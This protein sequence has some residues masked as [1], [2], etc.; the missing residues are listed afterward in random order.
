MTSNGPVI[1]YEW[2]KTLQL[3]Q[4]VEAFVDNGYDDLEVCKQIGDPDLD[5]IGVYTPHHRQ[6]VHDAVRRLKEEAK[7]TA[8][9]LYFTLEPMPPVAEVYT[10]HMLEFESKLRGS[11]SWTEPNSDRRNGGYIMG[12]Q[13]NL[14]LGNRRELVVYPK[15][16]LKIMI[17][18]KLIRD[19]IN[20]AKLP[21]SNKD[22]SLGTIDDLAQE[23]SEYYNTCFGDVSDRMEELRKRQVSQELDMEKQDPSTT[24]LQLRNEIQESLGFSSEVSTPETDRKMSLHKSSS[25]DGSGGKWDNKKKNKS[26]WQNFRKSQ[27]KPVVRQSSKGEDIGYV[28]SEITM[29]DEERIQLMMMVKEKMITVEEA[30]AR[31]HEQSDDEQSEDSVKFKRL[32]KL[33]NSTRRVRKKLIKVEEGKKHSTEDFLTLETPPR[34]EDNAALYTGVLK[35]PPLPLEASLPSLTH[36]QLSLDGDTDSLTT[37]PSSSSLDTWSGHK[38]VKTF[39]KSSST[40]GLIRPPQRTTVASRDLGG[41][42]SGVAGSGSSFSELDGCGVDNEGK[43]QRSTTDGEMRK[44]LSSISHGRTCSFGGFDLSNRSLHVVNTGSESNNKE[45]EAIYREVVKSPATSRISLGKKVKSVKETMRKRMSKKYSSSLSEQSSPDGA[46]GSPQSPLP[47]TDSLEKP[48]LKAGGSVESLR[49]SLSGQSSMSGQTVSTTDSSTSNRESVKSEDGDDEEPPYRGPF[50][51]RARVH[52]DFTPSPYDSD[53]L[54]LKRGDVI[55]IISKPPMGT[56]M[57]LLNNKVGTFK[58]IYVDV[59]NEEEEK[60]KRPV[61][62]KRK[63]RPPKPTSVEE[64]L[65]RINLKEHMPTFLFNGYEDLDTFKLLEEED[66]DELNIRDPQHRA[67]L[68]TAVELLQEYDSSSD[69]ERSGLSGSQEK[70]LSEGRGLVGDSPRD[71]GCYES[72]ENLENGKS[73][74]ASRSSRLPAGLQS[75]DYPTLPLALS[76]ETLQNNG[77]TQRAKFPKALFNKPSLKS[78]NFRGLRK[79]QRQSPIPASRSCEE[80][81]G[82]SQPTGPWKRSHSLGELN[83]EQNFEQKENPRFMLKHKKEGPKSVNISPFKVC[84][85]DRSPVKYGV[86]MVSPKGRADRPPIPSQLPLRS[87]CPMI[88]SPNPAEPLL[89]PTPSPDSS[90][91][92]ERVILT[93]TKKP[94]IPPPVPAKKSKERLA[95]GMRHPTLSLSSTPSPTASPTH[96]LNRSQPSSPVIRSPSPIL[97]APALPA[98]T[99]STPSSPSATSFVSSMGK[100]SDNAPAV[101]PPW[102]SDLGGKMAVMR[103]LSHTKMSPD[104]HTLLEQRLQTESIDLTEE[105]YSDKHGRCGIPQALIQRYS[106]DLEQDVKDVASSMDQL[107]VKEL[108]KQHRM[109]IPSRG[110][111]EVYRKPAPMDNISTVSDW[112]TSIGL[113]M[114]NSSL[115]AAGINSLSRV[116]LLTESSA[117]E[118]GV[119]DQRHA[120]RLVSEAKLVNVHR[121]FQS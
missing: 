103:K 89:S 44:A 83:L 43:L 100:D 14:T 56:W 69:P 102:L 25:E 107:R 108:R 73:K 90:A 13:R 59:L 24:S 117:W 36:D 61:R 46:P 58:F 71:S 91:S 110:L 116:A 23:Y 45:Q 66:L 57:G 33:V 50:C 52:T 11:K 42:I 35:K 114:Y 98:K 38:L 95:N 29:S 62:R 19:E 88:Q 18:D 37:S 53:S 82:P 54:K 1:V 3:S 79:A 51:G 109:A 12:A 16:K 77:K 41:S 72:N 93:H 55:D 39:S 118:A 87:P 27:H 94:P 26:F 28:A 104:L 64:L 106:E 78:F 80:L 15:L 49:S 32:H 74:K 65:E 85:E 121:E 86:P 101:Q 30:L 10:G 81:D 67:V 112:L 105:P 2:L 96:S 68:L 47:D 17:R 8:S 48:K 99:L 7:E 70:L 63:G 20:L 22:G 115:A 84:R 120:R 9:G 34:C 113:P 92:G 40:H 31:S 5:A 97:S 119:R 4:Y 60:P 111:T 76:S 21:Y 6:R 75:P